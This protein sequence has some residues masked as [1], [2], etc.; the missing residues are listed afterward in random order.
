MSNQLYGLGRTMARY[1]VLVLAVWVVVLAAAGST[2]GVLQ[3][4]TDD[5]VD[6][7]GASS[8]V[9]LR[10][11]KHVFPELGGTSAQ[12]VIVVPAGNRVDAPAVRSA[13]AGTVRELGRVNQVILAV[14]PF[15][16]GTRNAVSADGRA[17]VLDVYLTVDLL[18]VAPSTDRQIEQLARKLQQQLRARAG[19]GVTVHVGGDAFGDRVPH[20]SLTEGVGLLIALAVLVTMFGSMVISGMP[21]ATALL[22]VGVSTS[23]IYAATSV[24]PIMS[25]APM[26]AVMLGLAVGIDYALFILSRHRDQLAEGLDVEE[27][28][29]RA[30]ATAGSAVVVAGLTVVIALLG[31]AVVGIP[32]LTTM[33]VAAASAVLVAVLVALTAMP[34]LIAVAGERLRRRPSRLRALL[35]R[36][37]A[38]ASGRVPGGRRRNRIARWWVG[39][40]TARPLVTVLVVVVG[41]GACAVPARN[42]HLSLPDNGTLDPGT[43]ARVTYDLVNEHFGAGYNSPLLLTLDVLPSTDPIG[44]TDAVARDV[45]RIEGVAAVS[46]AT[47]NRSGDT[48]V[49]VVIPASAADSPQTDRLARRLR[50]LGP[51]ILDRYGVSSAVTGT[52]AVTMDISRRLGAALLPFGLLVVGLSVVLLMMVFRS[53]VVPVKAALGYLLSVGTALGAT[54]YVF[55]DGHFAGLLRVQH[56]GSVISFLPIIVMGVLFGLAMDYE[57]FLVSRMRER[58]V[59][60]KDADAAVREGF[61]A[62]STVVTAAATIMIGVFAA[63]VPDGTSSVKPIAFALAVGVFAD[64]FLVRMTLV[65]AVLSLLGERAWWLPGWLDRRLPVFDVE[66]QGLVRE[67]RLRDWPEPGAGTAS[68]GASV[69]GAPVVAARDLVVRDDRGRDVVH[70]VSFVVNPGRVLVLRGARPCG[71]S[72][73]LLTLAG[74]VAAFGG[75]LKVCGRVLPQRR[76]E[77][78]RSVAL[79]PCREG[80]PLP[81]ARQAVADGV[82]LLLIDDLDVVVRPDQWER[83]RLLL[84]DALAAGAWS[85]GVPRAPAAVVV[86]CARADLVE[87]V[88]ADLPTDVLELP[89]PPLLTDPDLPSASAG[90]SCARE[91]LARPC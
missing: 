82:R 48:S 89:C 81:V 11:L 3:K 59:H 72:A 31:L 80:D 86:T 57:M 19:G 14:D 69:V 35:A 32:F 91:V 71:K 55:G 20:L 7:P 83:L 88:V 36:R 62:A 18:H 17:A 73:L 22:G 28:V 50:D 90:E 49:I 2:A 39:V 52:N 65:P 5:S 44:L 13:V 61:C 56:V 21:I 77:V 24:T 66:G 42:L 15:A 23:G 26:L 76:R 67:L 37:Q 84:A 75:D 16:E 40:V 70:G 64:A 6:I 38:P 33:G 45:T 58:Y 8:M 63:F 74:R 41:L 79:V 10:H 47:P 53:V 9:A 27:S 54:T 43:P 12:L 85:S 78:R 34:A 87:R 30:T 25:T 29:A 4:G 60:H 1:R 68:V 51:T 46:L